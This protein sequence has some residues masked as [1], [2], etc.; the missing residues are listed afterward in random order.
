M[1]AP[2]SAFPILRET[3]Q[4]RFS[5]ALNVELPILETHA[6]DANFVRNK[7]NNLSKNILDV[8][9]LGRRNVQLIVPLNFCQEILAQLTVNFPD[10]QFV[11]TSAPKQNFNIIK[12]FWT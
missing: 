2:S 6:E 9:R 11:V 10:V 4:D 5:Q 7:V 12:V 8:A 3:L 1:S